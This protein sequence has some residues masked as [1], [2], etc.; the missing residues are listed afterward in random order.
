MRLLVSVRDGVEAREAIEG[1]ADVVDVK[2]PLA[3]PLGRAALAQ[4]LEIA[5]VVARSR[6][7]VPWTV[8]CGE[9]ADGGAESALGHVTSIVGSL[10][11]GID[12]PRLVKVGLANAAALG[13]EEGLAGLAAR[14][15]RGIAQA[16]VIYADWRRAAA[17]P[18]GRVVSLAGRL[19]GQMVLIDT[20]DK[21]AGS[22][23]D[24]AGPDGL[25]ALVALARSGG[26]PVAVAGRIGI[27]DAAAVAAI[28]PDVIAV[29]SAVCGGDRLGRVEAGRVE[30]ARR[31][32]SGGRLSSVSETLSEASR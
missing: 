1:G 6:R 3:G 16:F 28:A 22:V 18:P 24:L 10:P 29:R 21:A 15:P 4:T 27:G 7:P 32:F 19:A 2:E 30:A 20:F 26:L 12:P 8:A 23:F 14:L 17:P 9:F 13:W 11:R 5:S 25:G 31:A